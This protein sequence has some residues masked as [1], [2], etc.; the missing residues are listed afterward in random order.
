MHGMRYVPSVAA[1]AATKVFDSRAKK[2]EFDPWRLCLSSILTF[3]LRF[4]A[5]VFTRY[6][7]PSVADETR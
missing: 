2:P 5:G 6:R 7:P 1:N 4:I 3:F